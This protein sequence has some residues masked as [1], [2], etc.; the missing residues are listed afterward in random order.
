MRCVSLSEQ[1]HRRIDRG[2]GRGWRVEDGM[3]E[4]EGMQT[5]VKI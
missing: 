2:V 4:E 5:V 1:K 3:E